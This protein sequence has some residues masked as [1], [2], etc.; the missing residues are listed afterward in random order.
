MVRKYN[1]NSVTCRGYWLNWTSLSKSLNNRCLL[2]LLL[3]EP[4]YINENSSHGTSAVEKE[5]STCDMISSDIKTILLWYKMRGNWT[6]LDL[7]WVAS[8]GSLNSMVQI[9]LL[10]LYDQKNKCSSQLEDVFASFERKGSIFR[11][12]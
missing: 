2:H 9:L 10:K 5:K 12:Y 7:L 8:D 1:T 11:F 4:I 6:T 3:H